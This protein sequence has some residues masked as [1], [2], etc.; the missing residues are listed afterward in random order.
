MDDIMQRS[1]LPSEIKSGTMIFKWIDF[2]TLIKIG[3]S[4]FILQSLSPAVY[5]PLQI[6]YQ[7]FCAIVST[8][9]FSPSPYNPGLTIIKSYIVLIKKL[10]E[11]NVYKGHILSFDKK[12]IIKDTP[13]KVNEDI[14]L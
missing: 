5:T 9:F 11:N 2:I 3:I 6:I 10:R 7:I 13:Y 8:Y 1:L 12:E 14:T 4:W